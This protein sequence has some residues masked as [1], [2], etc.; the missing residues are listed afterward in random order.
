MNEKFSQIRAMFPERRELI[1]CLLI[2]DEDFQ[3]VCQDYEEVLR[4]LD[5]PRLREYSSDIRLLCRELE[6]EMLS[7]LNRFSTTGSVGSEDPSITIS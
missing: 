1:D 3:E 4:A 6:D 5:N 7:R 2:F